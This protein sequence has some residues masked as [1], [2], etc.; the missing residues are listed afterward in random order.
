MA[1]TRSTS[2]RTDVSVGFAA[3]EHGRGIAYARAASAA[4]DRLM[5]VPFY[6]DKLGM[7]RASGLCAVAAVARALRRWGAGRVRLRLE[8]AQLVEDLGARADL[9]VPIV[10]AYVRARCAINALDDCTFE[11]APDSDLTQRARAE[12][13]LHTAA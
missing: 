5:R 2:P 6:F 3:D 8:D 9:P 12:A 13:A 1:K 7:T 4:G 10:M 11:L